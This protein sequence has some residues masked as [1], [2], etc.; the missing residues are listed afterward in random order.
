LI[1]AKCSRVGTAPKKTNFKNIRHPVARHKTMKT[2]KDVRNTMT[3]NISTLV[4]TIDG[5]EIVCKPDFLQAAIVAGLYRQLSMDT[6][7]SDTAEIR[8][9]IINRFS[10]GYLTASDEKKATTLPEVSGTKSGR[11]SVPFSQIEIVNQA[12][13][14]VKKNDE[15]SHKALD[16]IAL[17]DDAKFGL[18]LVQVA[19]KPDSLISRA[20]TA[21]LEKANEKA[22]KERAAL[23]ET[24]E[25]I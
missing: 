16:N 11:K 23:L 3:A 13:S 24:I 8:E 10:R 9:E 4:V 15:A 5:K 25:I 1:A 22:A 6:A 21:L 7:K 20:I 2:L 12:R 19:D 18:L 14:M 17:Y